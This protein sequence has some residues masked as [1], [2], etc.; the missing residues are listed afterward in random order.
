MEAV[1]AE[2]LSVASAVVTEEPKVVAI[3][4]AALAAYRA[5]DQ[6]SLDAANKQANALA[7]G[8]KPLWA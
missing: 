1:L 8:L 2:I 7:D 5:N 3:V 6:A 4:E